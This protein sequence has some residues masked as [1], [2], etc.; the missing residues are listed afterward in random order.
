MQDF[1]TKADNSPPPG[2]QLSA[3]EF[4]NLATEAENAVLRGGQALN[5]ASASQLATSIFLHSIKAQSFQDS[6]VANVYVATPVSGTSGVLLPATYAEMSGS[7]ISFKASNANTAASTLNIGQTTGTLLGAKSIR[8]QADTAVPA[9]SILAGQYV[10]AVYN[11]S[12]DGGLGAWELLPWTS[13]GASSA[14]GECRLAK[15]GANL[16]LSRLNG[17]KI[18][19]NGVMQSVPSAGVS[20]APAGLT[21]STLYYIYAFMNAGVMTL[22]ASVTA[23]STDTTTGIEIKTG[24]ATRT[25]VGMVRPITGPAFVD[26]NLQ[27]FVLSW[28]NRIG[29][30]A[31][32]QQ[33]AT[34]STASGVN[35][36]LTASLTCEFLTWSDEAV[37]AST[38]VSVRSSSTVATVTSTLTFDGSTSG[39]SQSGNAVQFPTVGFDTPQTL[40]V[41]KTGLSEGYHTSTLLGNTTAGTATW[42]TS[43]FGFNRTLIQG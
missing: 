9:G 30:D 27:R 12:F 29:K 35:T 38:E 17:N 6:G 24:D 21:P 40:T 31:W 20:L 23:H 39:D 14:H 42:G 33:T 37:L 36:V 11:P 19:I 22:E 26:S 2:G 7:I 13:S 32:V 5:G 41:Y 3:A 1:G 43:R 25:L 34:A 8:T 15:S 4:N 10:Q 16:V 28:F 18:V